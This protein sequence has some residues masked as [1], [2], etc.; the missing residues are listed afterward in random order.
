MEEGYAA[1]DVDD[2]GDRFVDFQV[3]FDG[4]GLEHVGGIVELG[5]AAGGGGGRAGA[6]R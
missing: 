3:Q 5:E 6:G 4:A 2:G 1:V